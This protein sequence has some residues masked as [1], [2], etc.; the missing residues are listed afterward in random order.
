LAYSIKIHHSSF[1]SSF[2]F[3]SKIL[4]PSS[5]IVEFSHRI[6]RSVTSGIRAHGRHAYENEVSRYGRRIAVSKG[7]E[8]IG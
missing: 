5:V 6:N 7:R 3:P 2:F 8:G 1:I 4:F